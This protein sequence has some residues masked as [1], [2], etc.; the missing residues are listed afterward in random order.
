MARIAFFQ[1]LTFIDLLVSIYFR[2]LVILLRYVEI[3]IIMDRYTSLLAKVAGS[4][5]GDRRPIPVA[6]AEDE[7]R[8][9]REGGLIDAK[10][11]FFLDGIALT[12]G[13]IG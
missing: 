12:V 11:H 9:H 1:E 10:A 13:Q 7:V 5:L 2:T 3:F 8:L 6:A 4:G